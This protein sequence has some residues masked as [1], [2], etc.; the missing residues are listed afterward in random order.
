MPHPLRLLLSILLIVLLPGVATAQ[1]PAAVRQAIANAERGER[2]FAAGRYEEAY[3]AFFAAEEAM[4]APTVVARMGDCRRELGQLVEA[5][6]IFQKVAQWQLPVPAPP[7]WAAAKERAK[8]QIEEID[9]RVATLEIRIEGADEEDVMVSID[10]EIIDAGMLSAVILDPGT[11]QIEGTGPINTVMQDITLAEGARQAL[12]LRFEEAEG[13]SG[14]PVLTMPSLVAYG[15]GA[16]ALL[17]GIITG[18]VTLSLAGDIDEGCEGNECLASDADKGDTAQALATT[19][20]VAFVIVGVAG[21]AGLGL[22]WYP[23]DEVSF[24]LAPTSV[25]LRVSF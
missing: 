18:A 15:V 20:T 4:S 24:G 1:D 3:G 23:S 25:N 12:E 17:L 14:D 6:A 19:S 16:T 11:H 9:A 7:P 10:G 5:R 8:Q 21:A 2:A 13:A 22:M